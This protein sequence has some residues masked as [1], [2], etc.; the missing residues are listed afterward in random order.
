METDM[1]NRITTFLK[2]EEGA[3]AVEYGL[4]IGLIAV[5][6]VLILT[7]MGGELGTLFT[8]VKDCLTGGGTCT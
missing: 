5:A 7:A 2:D 8:K 3:S 6:V 1:L 4:I